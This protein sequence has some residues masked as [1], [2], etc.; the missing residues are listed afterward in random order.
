ML[1]INNIGLDNHSN[2]AFSIDSDRL[3][4]ND[5]DDLDYETNPILNITIRYLQK[6]FSNPCPTVLKLAFLERSI[7][8][9]NDQLIG[10]SSTII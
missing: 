4:V 10:S 1:V 8:L 3:L 6:R 7:D 9:N 5:S 2:L